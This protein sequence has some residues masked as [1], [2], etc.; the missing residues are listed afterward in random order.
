MLLSRRTVLTGL[1][2]APAI[3]KPI[4]IMPI[5]NIDDWNPYVLSYQEYNGYLARSAYDEARGYQYLRDAASGSN[6][7]RAAYLNMALN[8]PKVIW[9]VVRESQLDRDFVK[10]N[11]N[12]GI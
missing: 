7:E 11:I 8:D 10:R 1:I 6:W 12:H 3:V 4:N 9:R 2:T 5:F